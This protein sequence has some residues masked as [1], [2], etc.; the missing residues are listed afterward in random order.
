MSYWRELSGEEAR[1]VVWT[2]GLLTP[3]E[4][5]ENSLFTMHLHSGTFAKSTSPCAVLVGEIHWETE[6]K[7]FS[8]VF[9]PSTSAQLLWI[10]NFS[11]RLEF[12]Q[13]RVTG[14]N[15]R[16]PSDS[17]SSLSVGRRDVI[18]TTA[19]SSRY[20]MPFTC[21]VAQK[22]PKKFPTPAAAL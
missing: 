7:F 12:S 19:D 8:C 3:I 5:V 4:G 13:Y 20:L 17:D 10:T 21:E 15:N 9:L 16:R 1:S 6:V 18:A 22:M 14:R 11:C 2:F